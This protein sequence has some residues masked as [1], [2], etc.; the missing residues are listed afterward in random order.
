M[1]I[2]IIGSRSIFSADIE[3]Y[4]SS[5]DEII[6]GGAAG[7]D[8]LAAE[9]A[10][11]HGL[12]LTVFLPNYERYG[13]AAPIIRNREIVD[14]AEAVIAFW[15]GKSRGTL[16]TIKYAQKKGVPIKIIICD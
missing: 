3:R 1:K 6:S 7:V 10:K 5:A 2:A 4:A 9:Y 15:N 11:E 14:Y 13:R 8:T 12:K 16:S